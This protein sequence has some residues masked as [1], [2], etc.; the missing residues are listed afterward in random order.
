M[1]CRNHCGACCTAP[2]ISSPIPGMPNG[3][4]A[5]EPCIQLSSDMTCAIFGSP[6]RPKVCAG[7]MA[8]ELI[9]GD[10]R[11]DAIY[12]LDMLEHDTQ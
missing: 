12:I 11:E 1:L 8:E 9:C 6:S 10:T 7:F 4:L 2:S 3:K 5:G